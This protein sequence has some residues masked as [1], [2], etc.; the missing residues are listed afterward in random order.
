MDEY[1]HGERLAPFGRGPDAE[2]ET[3]LADG[4]A[5]QV[6]AS[7]DGS[8]DVIADSSGLHAGVGQVVCSDGF[9]GIGQRGRRCPSTM[10]D[11]R[12]GV[13]NSKPCVDIGSGVIDDATHCGLSVLYNSQNCSQ[14]SPVP[15]EVVT[16]RLLLVSPLN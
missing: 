3:V 12:L 2:G 16:V 1:H 14:S 8:V 9:V 11:W 7:S 15:V 13:W 10:P 6:L 4:S 5:D